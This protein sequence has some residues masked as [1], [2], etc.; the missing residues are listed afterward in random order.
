MSLSGAPAERPRLKQ[1]R[2]KLITPLHSP[3]AG[4]LDSP[5]IP[6]ITIFGCRS[7]RFLMRLK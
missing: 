5:G 3:R 6:K 1:I 4:N 2:T 7:T